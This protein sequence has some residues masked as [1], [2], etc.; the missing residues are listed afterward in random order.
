MEETTGHIPHL[1]QWQGATGCCEMTDDVQFKALIDFQQ[2]EQ[3]LKELT[4]ERSPFGKRLKSG[5]SYLALFGV[6]LF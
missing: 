2:D 5:L 3:N 4:E 1:D 6:V